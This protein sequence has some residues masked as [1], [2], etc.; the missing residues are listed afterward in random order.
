[1]SDY[2]N[3]NIRQ[4]YPID[5]SSTAS[6]D[7][8]MAFLTS[9]TSLSNIDPGSSYLL[10]SPRFPSLP[11]PNTSMIAATILHSF[12]ALP[13]NVRDMIWCH[14]FSDAQRPRIIEVRAVTEED[15]TWDI[16]CD[17]IMF[18]VPTGSTV[19]QWTE[20]NP[21]APCS[22]EMVCRESR[23]LAGS[24]WNFCFNDTHAKNI[25]MIE[26][27]KGHDGLE[28]AKYADMKVVKQRLGADFKRGIKYLADRDIIY[29]RTRDNGTMKALQDVKASTVGMQ[30]V[31]YLAMDVFFKQHY[32][33]ERQLF[34]GWENEEPMMKGLE[35]LIMVGNF[36]RDDTPSQ[37]KRCSEMQGLSSKLAGQ[38]TLHERTDGDCDIIMDESPNNNVYSTFKNLGMYEMFR[39]GN[40]EIGVVTEMDEVA[41]FED[42]SMEE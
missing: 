38:L 1:M 3:P 37:G 14:A 22:I 35:V 9:D 20:V 13:R 4:L 25:G 32:V 6:V 40:I 26:V 19:V 34:Q 15:L 17:N 27:F 29:L 10:S 2:F 18:P 42:Q 31:K 11:S 16:D 36:D 33:L 23:A 30:G 24:L 5:P 21:R 41:F 8:E 28:E 7:A 12:R 39:T